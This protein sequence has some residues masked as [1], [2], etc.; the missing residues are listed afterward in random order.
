MI[1]SFASNVGGKFFS[2]WKIQQL[3]I[4]LVLVIRSETYTKCTVLMGARRLLVK[5]KIEVK[6]EKMKHSESFFLLKNDWEVFNVYIFLL[7][8]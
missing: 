1:Q 7:K 4:D 5:P 2:D 3:A 6:S 8:K